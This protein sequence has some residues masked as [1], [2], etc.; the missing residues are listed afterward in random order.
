M[1][2]K[3]RKI[4]VEI[5]EKKNKTLLENLFNEMT[6]CG[7]KALECFAFSGLYIA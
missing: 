1:R 6:L 7:Y 4:L 5:E 3:T 2:E